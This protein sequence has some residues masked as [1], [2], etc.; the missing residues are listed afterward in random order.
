MWENLS[1]FQQV[2]FVFA[3][4][5]SVLLVVFL[6]LM[7][8]GMGDNSDFDDVT[9]G[10][11]DGTDD[12]NDGGFG[13][14]AGL[15]L[16]TLR[17]VLAFFAI[18][19]WTAFAFDETGIFWVFSLLLGIAAGALAGFLLA[20]AFK[21]LNKLE[22]VGNVDYKYAIGKK[23]QVYIKIPAREEGRGKVI[24]QYN[25]RF[26]EVDAV[27]SEGEDLLPNSFVE[28]VGLRESALLEVKKV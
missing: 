26:L 3:T 11:V 21:Q 9:A 2:V 13:L 23:A 1:N 22:Q 19:G 14:V 6:I 10:E 20:L 8:V 7:F 27:T 16:V 18:G 15:R 25:D 28:I 5:A 24:V 12:I 4:A 17:T